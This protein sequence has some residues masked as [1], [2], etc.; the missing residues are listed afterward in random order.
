MISEDQVIEAIEQPKLDSLTPDEPQ[1]RTVSEQA[2]SEAFH[3]GET[4]WTCPT[5]GETQSVWLNH[6]CREDVEAGMK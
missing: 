3:R 5:C 4:Q 1:A 6:W 2:A